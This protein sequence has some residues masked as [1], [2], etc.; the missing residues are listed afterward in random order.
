MEVQIGLGKA[1]LLLVLY[2][3]FVLMVLAADIWHRIRCDPEMVLL[4][5]AVRDLLNK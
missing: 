2:F 5:C 4:I 1:F 3:L